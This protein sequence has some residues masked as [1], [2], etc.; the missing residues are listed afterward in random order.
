[1]HEC[2]QMRFDFHGSIKVEGRPALAVAIQLRRKINWKSW[3]VSETLT[4]I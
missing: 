4:R 2:Y 3:L 1:M